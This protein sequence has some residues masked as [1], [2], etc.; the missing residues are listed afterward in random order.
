[1]PE[2][3]LIQPDYCGSCH[4]TSLVQ[5]DLMQ[6]QCHGSPPAVVAVPHPQG[7]QTIMVWPRLP[8]AHPACALYKRKASETN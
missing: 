2:P 4:F 3:M 6:V 5:E 7:M 8:R 1:M